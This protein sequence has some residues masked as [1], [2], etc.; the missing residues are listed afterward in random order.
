MKLQKLSFLSGVLAFSLVL[1][2]FSYSVSANTDEV[3]VRDE[4]YGDVIEYVHED[5][6]NDV[7][8]DVTDDVY[9]DV[10]DDVYGNVTDDVYGDVTDD[11]YGNV[12]DDVYGNV[13]DDVYGDVTEEEINDLQDGGELAVKL[14]A[15][16]TAAHLP[17]NYI[18]D[19][20][21]KGGKIT[22][23]KGDAGFTIPAS[24]LPSGKDLIFEM[25]EDVGVYKDAI[26]PVYD[27]TI[28]TTDGETISEFD[29]PVTL[30]FKV[31][32][33]LIDD[34]K[35]VKVFY[36]NESTG[37]WENYGGT[38]DETS[39]FVTTTT[40]H[41]SKYGVFIANANSEENTEQNSTNEEDTT[42][43][44]TNNDN[45]TSSGS[46]NDSE[47]TNE[48]DVE[49]LPETGTNTYTFLLIGFLLTTAGAAMLLIVRKKS[50]VNA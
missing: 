4:V 48:S 9:G 14:P 7:Y 43:T 37:K 15:N 28:K 40:T 3:S 22:I 12:T 27:F 6:T 26:G 49:K 39:G 35:K 31:D 24:I 46:N 30:K 47:T 45:N 2:P 23:D 11:V 38:Y 34:P 41:F 25:K 1:S 20:K 33:S 16:K 18:K 10:T 8:G 42:S 32:P 21:E 19:V 29:Q 50:V 44:I 36:F 5:V 17:A 13:T